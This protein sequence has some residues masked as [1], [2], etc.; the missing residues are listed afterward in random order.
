MDTKRVIGN[1]I[2]K[3]ISLLLI[4]A[5]TLPTFI[6]SLIVIEPSKTEATTGITATWTTKNHFENNGAANS[7]YT[8]STYLGNVATSGDND[9]NDPTDNDNFSIGSAVN[10]DPL[11]ASGGHSLVIKSDNSVWATGNN[12]SGQL[13]IGNNTQQLSW[14]QGTATGFRAV[15][16]NGEEFYTHSLALAANNVVWGTGRNANGQLGTGDTSEKNGWTQTPLTGVSAIATGHYHSLA[17]KDGVVWSVGANGNGQLGLGNTNSQTN[18]TQTSLTGVTAIATSNRSSYALKDGTVYSTGLNDYGQLGLGDTTQRNSWTA[19]TL[20]GVSAIA[21]GSRHV[22]AIKDGT[23]WAT[24]GNYNGQLGLGDTTQRNSWTATTL[25]GV[26]AIAGGSIHSMAIKNGTVWVTGNNGYGQLGLGD[27]TQRNSWTSTTLTNVIAIKAGNDFSLALKSD[28]KIY[29]TGRNWYGQLGLGDTTQRTS[30]TQS[31]TGSKQQISSLPTPV[32]LSGLKINADPSVTS[33]GTKAKWNNLSWNSASLPANTKIRFRVRTSDNNSSWSSWSTY[34]DQTTQGSTS[35]SGSLSSISVSQWLEIEATLE[36]NDGVGVPSVKDISASYDTIDA[37]TNLKQYHADE[38]SEITSYWTNES[39][40]VLK[41]QGAGLADSTNPHVEFELKET[42]ASFDGS[43]LTQ[44]S[45][46]SGG[47]SSATVSNLDFSKTYKWRARTTDTQQRRSAWSQYNSGGTALTI[48]RT[49]PSIANYQLNSGATYATIDTRIVTASG[50]FNDSGGSSGTLDV[51]F[52]QDGTYWGVYSGSGTSNNKAANWNNKTTVTA[53]GTSQDITN[54]WYLENDNTTNT[55][56]M[57]IRDA[58]GN[59]SG[60]M[61]TAEGDWNGTSQGTATTPVNLNLTGSSGD[62]LIS[63]LNTD[64]GDQSD[65]PLIVTSD[66]TLPVV[67]SALSQ[68]SSGTTVYVSSTTGFASGQKVMVMQMIGSSAGTKQ[69]VTVSSV[70]SSPARLILSSPGLSNTYTV[71][72]SSKAQVVK[73]YQY[74]DVSITGNSTLTVDSWNGSTGGVLFFKADGAVTI[75]SGSQIDLR[76]KGFSGGAS[77]G[78]T[79]TGPRYGAGGGNGGYGETGGGGGG[80]GYGGAGGAGGNGTYSGGAGGSSISSY[81]DL[82]SGGGAGGHGDSYGYGGGPAGVGGA[83]GGSVKIQAKSITLNGQIWAYGQSGGNADSS[84]Y[85]YG[86]AGGGGGAGGSVYVL[87]AVPN[88]NLNKII[89]NGGN[90]GSGYGGPNGGGGGG[91]KVHVQ[92][93]VSSGSSPTVSG[94]TGANS[95]GT[96]SPAY[97]TSLAFNASATLGV[98]GSPA[99]G[100]RIGN[101]SNPDKYKWTSVNW[102]GSNIDLTTYRVKVQARAS[103][104]FGTGNFLPIHTTSSDSNVWSDLGA[105][106]GPITISNTNLTTT[107]TKTLELRMQFEG[108]QYNTS[109]LNDLTV[110]SYNSDSI[111]LDN[112]APTLSVTSSTDDGSYKAG[113]P[114][115]ITVNSDEDVTL[116]SGN[117]KVPLETGD[118]EDR[119]VTITPFGPGQTASGTYTVQDGDNSSDLAAKSPL[120]L[121]P[122]ATLK[123]GAGNDAT[124]TIS[125]ENN[126][127]SKNIIVDAAAPT[128]SVS[129]SQYSKNLTFDVAYSAE[130]VGPSGLNY[131]KLFY[132]ANTSAPYTWA[133]YGTTFTSSPISFVAPTDNQYGFKLVAYDNALNEEETAPPATTTAPEGSTIVDTQLPSATASSPSYD[134]LSFNVSFSSSDNGLS[135]FKYA[136]LFYTTQTS[137]PYTW[138]QYGTTYTTSPVSFVAPTEGTYGF[139]AV[140]YDNAL[141]NEEADPPASGA[142]PEDS[143]IIDT[144]LPSGTANAPQ[145]SDS[146]TFNV[147]FS[148]TDNG[149]AGVKDVKLFYTTQTSAPYTWTQ[150]GTTHTGSEISFTA[151]SVAQYGFKVV[152]YDNASNEEETAPPSSSSAPESSTIVDIEDPTGAASSPNYSNSAT[153]NVSYSASDTGLSGLKNVKLYYTTQTSA[154]YTWTQYG[155]TYT[156][157]PISF[158]AA[159]NATYGFKVIAYDNALN[160]DETTPPSSSTAP[161][162]TTV[163]DTQ[164][165]SGTAVVSDYSNQLS[166]SVAYSASDPGPAGLKDVK[167]F[168]TTENSSP[169]TWT[170]YGGTYTSSP[171]SFEAAADGNYGFK[172]VSYDNASNEEET[173]PPATTTAPEDSTTVDTQ[174]PT[175]SASSAQYSSDLTFDV[176][177]DASDTGLSGLKYVKLFYTTQTSAPYTWTQ[178]GSTYTNTPISFVAPTD[179]TYGFKIVAYDNALNTDETAPPATSTAPEDTTIV[180]TELPTGNASSSAYSNS[181]TFNVSYSASDNGL[182][183]LKYVKLFYTTQTSA[184]YTWTQYG[185]TYTG[186]PISFVAPSEATYG[187]KAVAYDNALNSDETDPPEATTAPETSTIV[188]MQAPSGSASSA[189]YSM[190]L[191][192]DVSYSATDAGSSGVKEVKLFYTTQTS[193]PYTWTQYGTTHTSSPVSFTAASAGQ[194]GFK[195]VAYDNASNEE[196]TAPPS[197]SAAPEDSTIVD[198]QA[199]SGSASVSNYSN[200]LTFNVAYSASDTGLSGLKNVK[201]FY[202]TQTSAPYTWTQYGSTY[203]TSPISFVAPTTGNYGFKIVAYD[204]ALNEE[205]T[206]PPATTTTPEDSIVVDTEDPTAT[207][208]SASYSNNLTFNV[209]YSAS[210]IGLSGLK[211]IK[212]FYTTQTSAPYTWIQYGSTYT[213]SPIS[214]T[215]VSDGTYGFKAIAY[216]NALNTDETDPPSSSTAPEDSTVVDRQ[217]PSATASSDE[218]SNGL[219]FNVSYDAS[220]VGDAGLKEVKLYYTTQESS[221]Y[222]WTQYGSTYTS[223]PISFTAASDATY[224]FKIIAYDNALNTDET[225]PP[226]ITTAPEDSTIV[227]TTDPVISSV[228]DTPDP[229]SPSL[230]GTNTSISYYLNES[231][232]VTLKIYSGLTLKKTLVEDS[233]ARASGSHNHTWNGKDDLGSYLSD[234]T[235]TYK[236]DAVDNAGNGATQQEGTVEIDNTAPTIESITSSSANGNYKVGD[237]INVTVNFSENVTLSSGGTLNVTLETGD[238][239]RTV[240]ISPFTSQS[241]A[242]AIYTVQSGDASADL[243]ANSPL[244]LTTSTL[245]DAAGNTAILTIPSGQNISDSKAIV[246]DANAPNVPPSFQANGSNDTQIEVSFNTSTDPTPGTGVKYYYIERAKVGTSA[247]SQDYEWYTA[248]NNGTY[249]DE[250]NAAYGFKQVAKIDATTHDFVSGQ[251]ETG[252]TI[253]ASGNY[254]LT[255]NS[256]TS[257]NW[258]VYRVK[259]EDAAGNTLGYVFVSNSSTAD[260]YYAGRP[261][262]APTPSVVTS[263]PANIYLPATSASRTVSADFTVSDSDGIA[264]IDSVKLSVRR[265]G[266]VLDT[267]GPQEINTGAVTLSNFISTRTETNSTTY[268]YHAEYIFDETAL[269]GDYTI[270]V[271]TKDSIGTGTHDVL[272]TASV[273][274]VPAIVSDL[275]ASATSSYKV[276]LTWTNPRNSSLD[277]TLEGIDKYKIYMSDDSGD[278]WTSV[279]VNEEDYWEANGETDKYHFRWGQDGSTAAL[280]LDTTYQFKVAAMVGGD[281]N[282]GTASSV[283]TAT[284]LTPARPQSLTVTNVSKD[285]NYRLLV[286]WNNPEAETGTTMNDM[287]TGDSV[288]YRV[289][290]STTAN[291]FDGKTPRTSGISAYRI[292]STN[293][294]TNASGST[295]T[296]KRFYLDTDISGASGTRYYYAITAVDTG[297]S[298]SNFAKVSA[299][300][301]SGYSIGTASSSN[302]TINSAT[303]AWTPNFESNSEVIY[304]EV[305]ADTNLPLSGTHQKTRT[306]DSDTLIAAD[307][308]HSVTLPGLTKNTKYRYKVK[309]TDSNGEAAIGSSWSYFTTANLTV[310]HSSTTD[311]ETTLNS[312]TVNFSTNRSE[313]YNAQ[314]FYGDSYSKVAQATFN[315]VTDTYSTSITNLNPSTSYAY[316]IVVKDSYGNEDT[317]TNATGFTTTTFTATIT[318]PTEQASSAIVRWDTPGIS[319]DSMVEYYKTSDGPTSRKAA[320]NSIATTSHV[321]TI[322]GLEAGQEYTY[323]VKSTDPS[324][325]AQTSST[326]TL[327]TDPFVVSSV[328]PL[329][330]DSNNLVS[331]LNQATINWISNEDSTSIVQYG[332]TTD[333]ERQEIVTDMDV[334][335]SV[336]IK[337]LRAGTTYHYRVKSIDAYNNIAVSQDYTFTTS[338]FVSTSISA[339]TGSNSAAISWV[340]SPNN[341][342]DATVK[343]WRADQ[344]IDEA[345]IAGT[346]DSSLGTHIVNIPGLKPATTYNYRIFSIDTSYNVAISD[347][348]TFETSG[349]LVSD[350]NIDTGVSSATIT[351]KTNIDSDSHILYGTTQALGRE[352][353]SST[354]GTTHSVTVSNLRPGTKY[355]YR[356]KSRDEYSNIAAKNTSYFETKPFEVSSIKV[357][358]ETNTAEIKWATNIDS[359]SYVEYKAGANGVSKTTGDDKAATSHKV[360]LKN[361]KDSTTYYFKIKSRDKDD[362]LAE[363]DGIQTFSTKSLGNIL[364]QDPDASKINEMELTATSAKISWKTS[365]PTT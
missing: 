29:S 287:P 44:G 102:L 357:S 168:Y 144:Q 264:D 316:K 182:S 216:D 234:G 91:G 90:G 63:S 309:S 93:V 328:A 17:L 36:S 178:Y 353:G 184:P 340:N 197:S 174:D 175:G 318:S 200:S 25:T 259:S 56:Y 301:N 262:F 225:A 292:T 135:G 239:D 336:V 114:I 267:F 358:T 364:T 324:T 48:E 278:T 176:S 161:E 70:A 7:N 1:L 137:A 312:A 185:S 286:A 330:A 208:S 205:E 210:D 305:D 359:T 160:T 96:P 30:W 14:Q 149:D 8:G 146:L 124:L 256:L 154:P 83:G 75:D 220:D 317:Y 311:V 219:T 255:D 142:A 101:V 31:M 363:S 355:Y 131:V 194:Y 162:D 69:E 50:I 226:A 171:I 169:Y 138:T 249:T 170:Q 28:G 199:P 24:G 313:Q 9:A 113:D 280:D 42:S 65:G 133:Q 295:D 159:S 5:I 236:I 284:T 203:T 320:Y 343:Y 4:I 105:N 15:S 47:I 51:Q 231:A 86:S 117:L 245:Q 122:G 79:G 350:V 173:A 206:A 365:T 6:F 181:L 222:T 61:F 352:T 348:K 300:A 276:K 342:A 127:A 211:E 84:Y 252:D 147:P 119:E 224:G 345:R 12:T 165:P 43:N 57:R 41:A 294:V 67:R 71:D 46:F 80:G 126:M 327:E 186:S 307:T 59:I 212:L 95:G 241:S 180:D 326:G 33:D 38:T 27:T 360:E 141:N 167:L 35:G 243:E 293:G 109:V 193:A 195:V 20:T 323:I 108:D 116:A 153:F 88:V 189:Q 266:A 19:T 123:D 156:T 247:P 134:D 315:D 52:S 92:A 246:V 232:K 356:I 148:A 198:T 139:K 98:T 289:Y 297:G 34:F 155:S 72:G 228:I 13:G 103:D 260:S 110:T 192:F 55:L 331:T 257:A 329:N 272:R 78:S 274:L 74:S 296:L 298:E 308:A 190:N 349:L 281:S 282:E 334:N 235:Y 60:K 89:A 73:I 85:Y 209:S 97:S 76:Y 177:Y 354:L 273:K 283:A 227:D 23:I 204:N 269:Y 290:R 16:S 58:A 322:S 229:F 136:K 335:H 187:F 3:C 271:E 339:A 49:P 40:V 341:L 87:S 152:A 347:I 45:N 250:T 22:F 115:N 157:S 238:T 270:T 201:L 188:D 279:T 151:A 277:R 319:S 106:S 158:T 218:Y 54:A 215:A 163:V 346:K 10:F 118:A 244:T 66:T 261:N 62:A 213:D 314:V 303:I 82:G 11:A 230:M 191:T 285:T 242:S 361:L 306:T 140:A 333:Y 53:S 77:D 112:V 2:D 268:T 121:D 39:S 130:D 143:T 202:T 291:F 37:P 310:S 99:V 183:G 217:A 288:T 275:A 258:Y 299:S 196:E 81:P 166:F 100:L 302:I 263:D 248:A 338:E 111:I 233:T 129:P 132:T 18:W 164:L 265:D 125:S 172:I 237:T 351:W 240:Y 251:N 64:W 214:F 325:L 207:A 150:Y 332:E 221:P 104:A 223:S 128:G 179:A 337:K 254:L 32:T 21:G 145:Y 344:N 253:N 26:S 321:I 304:Q 362:N 120:T 68:T 107:P 94:G